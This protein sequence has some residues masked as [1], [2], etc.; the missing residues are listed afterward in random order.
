MSVSV[1]LS[2]VLETVIKFGFLEL[3]GITIGMLAHGFK[4]KKIISFLQL[5]V[6]LVK[7]CCGLKLKKNIL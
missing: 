1:Q 7:K 3:D 2:P 5:R 4:R 6:C